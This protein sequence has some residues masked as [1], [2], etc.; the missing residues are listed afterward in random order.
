MKLPKTRSIFIIQRGNNYCHNLWLTGHLQTRSW[1]ERLSMGHF[2]TV[3][4]YRCTTPVLFC[5][6]RRSPPLIWEEND[7]GHVELKRRRISVASDCASLWHT[8]ISVSVSV[9]KITRGRKSKPFQGLF[10]IHV[11]YMI[12]IIALQMWKLLGNYVKRNQFNPHGS[13]VTAWP[14]ILPYI[15]MSWIWWLRKQVIWPIFREWMRKSYSYFW[16]IYVIKEDLT[17]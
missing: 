3:A 13:E 12:A 7:G 1:A 8:Q 10:K 16:A 15:F 4:W 2:C 9:W 6:H 17:K 11:L 14:G 5:G